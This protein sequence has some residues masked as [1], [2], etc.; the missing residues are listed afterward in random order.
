MILRGFWMILSFFAS[1]WGMTFYLIFHVWPSGKEALM[2]W[3]GY[4]NTAWVS[5]KTMS[6]KKVKFNTKVWEYSSTKWK[7]IRKISSHR[8][9]SSR[10]RLKERKWELRKF[11]RNNKRDKVQLFITKNLALFLTLSLH[12]SRNTKNK[13]TLKITLKIIQ[14]LVIISITT[15]KNI[16]EKSLE[17]HHN[18]LSNWEEVSVWLILKLWAGSICTTTK[19]FPAGPGSILSTMHLSSQISLWKNNPPL[20]LDSLSD[21]SNNW[22]QSSLLKHVT[23]FLQLSIL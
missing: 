11:K 19:E 23:P 14:F 18:N 21:P 5:W 16:I 12:S 22:W 20:N 3:W 8:L 4:T 13:S 1:L 7:I 17:L 10:T 9:S 15:R 6:R 2:F